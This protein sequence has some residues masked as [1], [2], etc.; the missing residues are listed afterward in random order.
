[1]AIA[2][3]DTARDERSFLEEREGIVLMADAKARIAIYGS[4]K[5]VSALS[6]FIAQ[7]SQTRTPQGMLA[8]TRMCEVMRD[9]GWDEKA[10][11]DDIHKLLFGR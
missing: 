9:A 3:S 11:F 8:L 1:V 2:Q 10:S 4:K 7:G 5:A 6:A